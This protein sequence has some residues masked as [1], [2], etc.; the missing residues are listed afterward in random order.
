V[1]SKAIVVDFNERAGRTLALICSACWKRGI[2][3]S[4]PQVVSARHT[5]RRWCRVC[6][7]ERIGPGRAPAIAL[8]RRS[9]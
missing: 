8:T 1:T 5:P 9:P 2:K 4:V 6:A 3:R 7:K